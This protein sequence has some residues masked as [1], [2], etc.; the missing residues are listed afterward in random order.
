MYNC[1]RLSVL[2]IQGG[3][4]NQTWQP[5]QPKL[6]KA[7]FDNAWYSKFDVRMTDFTSLWR[8]TIAVLGFRGIYQNKVEIYL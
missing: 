5:G 8:H 2:Y 7:Q 4:K 1:Y 3:H 6:S